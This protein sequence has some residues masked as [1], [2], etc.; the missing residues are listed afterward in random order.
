MTT[1]TTFNASVFAS[2][3]VTADKNDLRVPAVKMATWN[4]VQTSRFVV[5]C[6]ACQLTNVQKPTATAHAYTTKQ[7]VTGKLT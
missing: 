7:K 6:T 1:A 4:K 2:A 5:T 3:L